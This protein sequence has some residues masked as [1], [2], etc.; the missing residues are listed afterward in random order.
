MLNNLWLTVALYAYPSLDLYIKMYRRK[1][2][3]FKNISIEKL[4]GYTTDTFI[5][6]L[7]RLAEKAENLAVL[8]H[9][10]DAAMFMLDEEKR[11]IVKHFYFEEL[12]GFQ[13]MEAMGLAYNTYRYKKK[14]G[15]EKPC[16]KY[17]YSRNDGQEVC[18]VL[19]RRAPHRKCL[20][21][22]AGE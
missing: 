7:D 3:A 2:K 19:R 13:I 8:K 20:R 4:A 14:G 17:V 1:L 5:K 10:I 22:C 15:A 12:S 6:D 21:V 11:Q 18:G 16:A 9:T